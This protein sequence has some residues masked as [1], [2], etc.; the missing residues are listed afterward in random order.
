MTLQYDTSK[1]QEYTTL[2]E[3]STM[4]PFQEQI[5]VKITSELE[6]QLPGISLMVLK[7]IFR[8]S[9]RDWVKKSNMDIAMLFEIPVDEARPHIRAVFDKINHRICRILRNKEDEGRL[10]QYTDRVFDGLLLTYPK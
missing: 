8:L 5:M 2:R 9:I 6:K 4:T 1:M 7:G 10:K 3:M